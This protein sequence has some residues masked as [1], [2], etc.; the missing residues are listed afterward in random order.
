M[1]K[2]MH[3]QVFRDS[4]FVMSV[5][6]FVLASITTYALFYQGLEDESVFSQ[7]KIL[8]E[9]Q[10]TTSTFPRDLAFSPAEEG[11]DTSSHEF[12]LGRS[13]PLSEPD[14]KA[15][16]GG[17]VEL[18]GMSAIIT[19]GTFS[20]D[21]YLRVDRT[22]RVNPESAD[23]LWQVSDMWNVRPRYM[24]NDNEIV[25]GETTH[26]YILS[27]PY[28]E[29][30]LKTDQGVRFAE[31]S[32]KLIRGDTQT[33]P[34]TV[35]NTS[36]VDDVN[37]TVA[38]RTKQGGY[39]FVG[40]GEYSGSSSLISSNNVANSG[41]IVLKANE[42]VVTVTP[43]PVV[44]QPRVIKVTQKEMNQTEDIDP[45]AALAES[46]PSQEVPDNFF[47]ALFGLLQCSFLKKGC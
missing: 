42:I 27:F 10:G 41:G 36:V 4:L 28:S 30:L 24:D 33:G 6:L 21:M 9:D 14:I 1:S 15:R 19:E 20:R 8:S 16:V 47:T 46:N 26:E 7:M 43:T 45:D 18:E 44:I 5:S 38:V 37:N 11:L 34:W 32:V 40:A 2:K 23:G 29:S 22:A 13:Y 17:T 39:F 12:V 31:S 3:R 35:M 25:V